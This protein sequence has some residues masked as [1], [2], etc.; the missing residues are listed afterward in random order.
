MKFSEKISDNIIN[1]IITYIV[2]LFISKVIAVFFIETLNDTISIPI[3]AILTGI[4]IVATLIYKLYLKSKF[5]YD[6]ETLEL[7]REIYKTITEELM[8]KQVYSDLKNNKFSSYRFK[9]SKLDF[10]YR[11][12]ETNESPSFKFL[13]PHLEKLK[14]EWITSIIEFQKSSFEYIYSCNTG[15]R[16]LGIPREW[17]YEK[18][19]EAAKILSSKG[20]DICVK[21]DILVQE[22]RKVLKV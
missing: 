5:T 9:S 18:W 16:D 19:H 11:T 4:I 2:A 13:N 17:S 7:D 1:Q 8:P 20:Q 10:I 14:Q 15:E 12:T 3:W 21:F 6:S 22:G